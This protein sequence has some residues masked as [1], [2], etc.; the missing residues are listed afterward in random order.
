M[1]QRISL[2]T[3]GVTDLQKARKFYEMLGWKA[4][5]KSQENIVFFQ[6]GGLALALYPQGLLAEDA[7]QTPEGNGSRGITL[8]M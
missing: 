7:L 3:L 8:A 4:S 5:E 6:L 2:I 1:E